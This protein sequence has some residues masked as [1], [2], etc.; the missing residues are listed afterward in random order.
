MEV[1]RKLEE[2]EGDENRDRGGGEG[3]GVCSKEEDDDGGMIIN[4]CGD[5]VQFDL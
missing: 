4:D 1:V 5:Y 2:R 3:E